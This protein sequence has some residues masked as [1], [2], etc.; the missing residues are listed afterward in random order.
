MRVSFSSQ[1][2]RV[3][4][5]EKADEEEKAHYWYSD[6]ELEILLEDVW[7]EVE[8]YQK[9]LGI[10]QK[11][12]QC[13]SS[14]ICECLGLDLGV[15][16][17]AAIEKSSILEPYRRSEVN[18]LTRALFKKFSKISSSSKISSCF[19]GLESLIF[20][21]IRRN[22]SIFIGKILQNQHKGRAMLETAILEG[23]PD[24]DV[25]KMK[26]QLST[27]M[28]KSS[29]TLSNWFVD[30]ALVLAK[31][32]TD[33]VHHLHLSSP[34]KRSTRTMKL[35]RLRESLS[36]RNIFSM[37]AKRGNSKLRLLSNHVKKP[38]ASSQ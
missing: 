32:D 13:L 9:F 25:Q 3:R 1:N 34:H 2:N 36:K 29:A 8:R 27:R 5:I 22:R 37:A 19:R 31:Y 28:S 7:R 21:A 30:E 38:N 11:E 24:A 12:E 14:P 18:H 6:K 16:L 10:N 15:H 33:R 26:E 17:D 23:V 35:R 20:P 4:E